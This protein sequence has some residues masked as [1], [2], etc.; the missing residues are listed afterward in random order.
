[1]CQLVYGYSAF[2]LTFLAC[3]ATYVEAANRR[4]FDRWTEATKVVVPL[5][6]PTLGG[7]FQGYTAYIGALGVTQR[8]LCHQAGAC[9]TVAARGDR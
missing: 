3:G 2:L 1:M 9:G 5:L 7:V 8:R 4:P 6:A